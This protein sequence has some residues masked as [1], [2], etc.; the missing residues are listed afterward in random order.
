MPVAAPP[1]PTPTLAGVRISFL[2]YSRIP[3]LRTVSLAVDGDSLVTLR[4]GEKAGDLEVV[5]IHPDRVEVKRNGEAF[6]V[7]ARN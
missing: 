1:S 5:R 2:A 4:E 3:D 7:P 6:I